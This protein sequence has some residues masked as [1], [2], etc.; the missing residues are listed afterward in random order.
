MYS[1]MQQFVKIHIHR[2][3]HSSILD[4]LVHFQYI[5]LTSFLQLSYRLEWKPI[6]L[7]IS[8]YISFSETGDKISIKYNFPKSYVHSYVLVIHIY[9]RRRNLLRISKYR[10]E[11]IS[12][13]F[14]KYICISV[15]DFIVFC[16]NYS[17]LS[18]KIPIYKQVK[19]IIL[20]DFYLDLFSTKQMEAIVNSY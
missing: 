18:Y 8:I 9:E 7:L 19:Y 16:S 10:I 20:S 3:C 11:Y 17:Y 6:F 2:N 5:Q 14:N 4:F 1:C 13:F 15:L 12:L